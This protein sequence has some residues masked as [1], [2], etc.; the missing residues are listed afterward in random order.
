MPIRRATFEDL[1]H[2]APG[3]GFATIEETPWAWFYIL[4]LIM[5]QFGIQ[6]VFGR[7]N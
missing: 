1:D 5:E 2:L 7:W 4:N 3:E 6:P